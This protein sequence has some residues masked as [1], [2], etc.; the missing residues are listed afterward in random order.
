MDDGT[1][2]LDIVLC[3]IVKVF[4]NSFSFSVADCLKEPRFSS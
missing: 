4:N 3:F 1:L 2:V